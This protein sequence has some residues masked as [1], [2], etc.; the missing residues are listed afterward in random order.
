M[1]RKS[2]TGLVALI[3]VGAGLSLPAVASAHARISPPVSVAG[4]LQLYSLAVPTEKSGLTTTKLVMT[5]PSGFGI[6]SFVP[7]ASPWHVQ[8]A[9]TGSGDSAVVT[10]VT[11]T[12]GNTPTG[13][14]TLFQF[15][16]QPASAKTYTFQ[17][18]Q[19]YS[20]GS[21][22]NWAGSESSAAPAPTI[23]AESSLGGGVS[24]LTIIALVVGVLG[25]LAGGFALHRRIEGARARV[26]RAIR[27]A[28]V[29][30]VAAA[31]A[32]G[33]ALP[34]IADAHAYLVKTVPAA[35]VVLNA[36][37]PNIQLTYDEAVEPRFAIISVT[38]VGGHQETTGP[39]H[40]SPSNPD[41][42]VVPLRPNLPE[43]WY[44]IYWRAISVDGHPVNGAFTYAVGPNPG[45]A[46]QFQVPSISATATTPGLLITRWAMFVFVMAA[47]GLF[48]LRLLIARPLVRTVEGVTLK[49]LTIAFGIALRARA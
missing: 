33:V 27:T 42:L 17:V 29:A 12:G 6:D 8:L 48:V 22:V 30:L 28:A 37:P 16:A 11:L 38:D 4:K 26:S 36:P 46:P 7:A 14:D 49:P 31:V 1:N 3:A 5:V 43:G 47:I 24:V 35:S 19:T 10:K 32:A 45:P 41:T 15:L 2:L 18:E 23:Q 20:D 39:V 9:Q 13:E 25:L 44:L 40:R 21:I 34:A